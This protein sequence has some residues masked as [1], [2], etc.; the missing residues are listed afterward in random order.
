MHTDTQRP[1]D[2]GT[3]A[4][5]ELVVSVPTFSICNCK[6]PFPG[7]LAWFWDFIARQCFGTPGE[8]AWQPLST[9]TPTISNMS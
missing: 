4:L 6:Y 3:W 8:G 1:H 2:F 9:Q 5:R 7:S